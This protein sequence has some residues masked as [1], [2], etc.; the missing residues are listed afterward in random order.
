MEAQSSPLFSSSPSPHH[1]IQKE[2]ATVG[3]AC[4][5]G[6]P[7]LPPDSPSSPQEHITDCRRSSSVLPPLSSKR[8]S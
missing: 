6:F 4:A 3:G 2:E 7:S 8:H 5:R 1:P